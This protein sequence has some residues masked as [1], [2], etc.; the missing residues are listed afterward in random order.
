MEHSPEYFQEA[1]GYSQL[2][3]LNIF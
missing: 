3:L 2:Q 1:G